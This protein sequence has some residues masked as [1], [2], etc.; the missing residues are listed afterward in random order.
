MKKRSQETKLLKYFSWHLV[1]LWMMAKI[2]TALGR[3]L[4][5]NGK[6]PAWEVKR[7][8]YKKG[9]N[10]IF[11]NSAVNGFRNLG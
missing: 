7:S 10:S 2:S 11:K 5:Y 6:R 3:N 1:S 4:S 8:D 9:A